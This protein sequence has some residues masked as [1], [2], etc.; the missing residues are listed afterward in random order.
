MHKNNSLFLLTIGLLAALFF[1]VTFLVNRAISLDGGHWF[2]SATLRYFYTLLFL[3]LILVLFKGFTYF[4]SVLVEF[5]N[6]YRFWLLSGTI[7]FGFFYALI[8]FA[9]DYSPAWV[10]ATTWQ[11]TILASLFVLSFFGQKISKVI[12]LCTFFVVIGITMVNMSH[13][14]M[15]NIESLIYGAIPVLIAAFC[16]PFGNQLVWEAKNGRKNLPEINPEV[17]NNAFSKVFLLTLG[18]T[19]LWIVLFFFVDAQLPSSGQI[20]NVAII[21]LFS[22]VIATSLFLYARNRANTGTKLVIV[23]ATQSG[24]VFFALGG[25]I[26]FLQAVLPTGLG[27][28][29]IFVTLFGLLAL[30]KFDKI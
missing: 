1:S 13:F 14:E 29:G 6:N 22:G 12:W 9:A 18:S 5:F 20:T 4:K 23:D 26:L 15:S 27:I 16:Y 8:C 17:I 11:I 24:E 7:G 21:S 28:V 3:A 10:V 2:W 19:P 30:V 25:E